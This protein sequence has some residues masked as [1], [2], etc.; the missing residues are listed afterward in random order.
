MLILHILCTQMIKSYLKP[1]N[2]SFAYLIPFLLPVLPLL[3]SHVS[4]VHAG[5]VPV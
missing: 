3:F 1:F 5:V 4:F 2:D